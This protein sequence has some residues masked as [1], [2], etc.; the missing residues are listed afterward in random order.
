MVPRL[1]TT[2]D[3]YH[4]YHARKPKHDPQA[5][6]S[7]RI[8]GLNS[9]QGRLLGEIWTQLEPHLWQHFGALQEGR[10][11]SLIV[12]APDL[13]ASSLRKSLRLPFGLVF[14]DRHEAFHTPWRTPI[15]VN[16]HQLISCPASWLIADE[17]LQ[18]AHMSIVKG[19]SRCL[20][21]NFP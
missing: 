21:S 19:G 5:F 16:L 18:S 20:C 13:A 10:S 4:L 15:L 6:S 14:T 7:C 8:L 1:L 9:A 17:L 2:Q 11:E 12:V 3:F